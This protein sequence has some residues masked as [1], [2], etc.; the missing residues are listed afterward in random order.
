MRSL[1][2]LSQREECAFSDNGF[3][4]W[5]NFPEACGLFS[6]QRSVQ[7]GASEKGT[8]ADAICPNESLV[9]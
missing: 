6:S 7:T 3:A 4:G 2:N 5:Q 9:G 1:E 8:L